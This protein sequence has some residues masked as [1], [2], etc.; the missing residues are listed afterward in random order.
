MVLSP[1]SDTTFSPDGCSFW[2]A[3]KIIGKNCRQEIDNYM[4]CCEH[5]MQTN[6]A[7]LAL[8]AAG[9]NQRAA[10]SSCHNQEEQVTHCSKKM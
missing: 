3:S 1:M 2:A 10:R 7:Q 4:D 8:K 9:T 6:T 5:L